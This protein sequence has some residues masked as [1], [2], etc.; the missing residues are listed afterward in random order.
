MDFGAYK[1]K[2]VLVTG[3]TGFKGTWLTFWLHKLG[4]KVVGLSLPE[5]YD[6][7]IFF[8]SVSGES[9]CTST[10]GDV[11]NW[12][13]VRTAVHK[14]NPDL[15]F[16]LA[17]QPLVQSS[18]DNPV[19]TMD[20]NVM[21][22]AHVLD[23]AHHRKVPVVVVTSDKCYE[24]NEWIYSYRENDRL[25]GR[26]PYSASKAM[27]ELMVNS[28]RQSYGMYIA[29]VRAGN[30]I[31][32]GDF[33]K[34]RIVSDLYLG[35]MFKKPTLVRFPKATRPWQHVT[36]PLGGYLEIGALLMSE[37]TERAKLG[38]DAWNFGPKASYSVDALVREFQKHDLDIKVEIDPKGWNHEASKLHLSIEKATS[39]LTWKP[40]FEF[41]EAVK[42]TVEWYEFFYN[43]ASQDKLRW[44][45]DVQIDA[46]SRK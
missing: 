16:H 40:K 4:A 3:H 15:I 35:K 31:G 24:N 43:R 27:V 18:Y 6:Q 36:E 32:G 2:T 28:F 25:G 23:M 5:T 10:D 19:Y 38:S 44:L 46:W 41:E 42:L 9:F 30:V 20:V 29:S 7:R 33:S 26:D 17:A 11:R 22:T 37:D 13:D 14:F 12:E 21:G 45:M 34:N 39:L 1:N 8:D